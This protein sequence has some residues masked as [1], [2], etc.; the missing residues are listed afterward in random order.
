MDRIGWISVAETGKKVMGS[1]QPT[2]QFQLNQTSFGQF[3]T[4]IFGNSVFTF[5]SSFAMA[6]IIKTASG[7]NNYK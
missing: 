6:Y 3:K 4:I 1:N 7:G 2:R 5:A